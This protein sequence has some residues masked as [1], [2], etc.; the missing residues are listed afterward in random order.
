MTEM[1]VFIRQKQTH[2]QKTSLRLPEGKE[3]EGAINQQFG[4]SR[5]TANPGQYC[6][7]EINRGP[8]AQHREMYSPSTIKYTEEHV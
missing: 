5:H 1:K 7:Q 2:K 3:G 8:T 6:T 4:I